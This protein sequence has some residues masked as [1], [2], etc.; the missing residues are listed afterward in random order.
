[1]C[2]YYKIYYYYHFT[3]GTQ[4]LRGWEQ[5]HRYCKMKPVSVDDVKQS[6]VIIVYKKQELKPNVFHAAQPKKF[7]DVVAKFIEDRQLSSTFCYQGSHQI[8]DL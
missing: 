3:I 8:Q 1:M 6:V 4:F 7:F 5:P 2:S